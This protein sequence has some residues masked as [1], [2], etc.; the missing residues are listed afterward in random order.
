MLRT[1]VHRIACSLALS[2]GVVAAVSV[3]VLADPAHAQ[4]RVISV[5]L[6]DVPPIEPKFVAKLG[7]GPSRENSGIVKSRNYPDLF[8]MHN[9]S[10][11]EPRIYPIHRDGTNYSNERYPDEYGVLIGGAINVDWEDITCDADGTLI[12][13]DV[14]NN[15][16]DRRDLTLYYVDEPAPT[17]GRTTFRKKVSVR[18]PDQ[19]EFPA[20]RDKFDF[21][22][23]AVFTVGD[24]VYLLTKN[25]SNSYTSLFS[26]SDPKSEAVN[27]LTYVA[28]F[29]IQGQA[30]AADC[31]TDGKRLAVLSY[32]GLWLFVRE[33]FD[34]HFFSA[35]IWWMPLRE[36]EAEALCFANEGTLLLADEATAEVYEVNISK[37]TKVQ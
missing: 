1:F 8:W 18:Y 9:D 22:C 16:N 12:I 6:P 27:S 20:S 24:T 15:G 25:R 10:G 29:D 28:T 34:Q 36:H 23:E 11:D 32:T 37:L 4:R 14:G 7:P 2:F 3:V 33:H 31:S 21:D 26:L 5:A 19:Q 35:D 17:A 30:V 13:A